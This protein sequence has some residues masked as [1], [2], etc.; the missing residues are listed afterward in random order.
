MQ[1]RVIDK[2]VDGHKVSVIPIWVDADLITAQPNENCFSLKHD[3]VM[4]IIFYTL[5]K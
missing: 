4:S 1:T 3:T 2:S 5:R